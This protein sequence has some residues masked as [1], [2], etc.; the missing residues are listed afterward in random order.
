MHKELEDETV[1][2]KEINKF[3]RISTDWWKYEGKFKIL[4]DI[5][6]IRIEYI[7]DTISKYFKKEYDSND[8]LAGLDILDV[9][10]GGGLLSIPISN[11]GASVTAIDASENNIKVAKEYSS[12]NNTK[13]VDFRHATTSELL[14]DHKKYDVVLAMEVIEHVKDVD[15]FLKENSLLLKEGGL[16]FISTINRNIKSF[17][18]A[19]L[20]AE[21]ILD[22][23]PVG[24][25]DW[26]KFF[27]P[28]EIIE[29]LQPHDVRLLDAI[30]MSYS[31]FQKKWYTSSDLSV[32][33][34]LCFEKH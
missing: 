4:H 9:G 25:H 15:V 23:I 22:W 3:S 18:G 32:N 11:L 7:R 1:D 21:Y 28:S 17:L 33:Y 6:K 29:K 27:K 31:I 20:L 10:C 13:F 5:N 19:K 26:N 34:I 30:G 24:T 2:I 16:I 8:I 14:K 12:N